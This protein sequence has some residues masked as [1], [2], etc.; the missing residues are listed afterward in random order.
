MKHFYGGCFKNPCPIILICD[1]SQCVSS[2]F[3]VSWFVFVFVFLIE[4][5][6]FLVL[7]MASDI[8]LYPG[9]FAWCVRRN[10]PV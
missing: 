8:L 4:A 9:H 3:F 5:V 2:L 6:L 7:C 1:L 10:G